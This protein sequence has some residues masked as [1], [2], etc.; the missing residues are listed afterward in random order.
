MR[1]WAR[2]RGRPPV[3]PPA[4]REL[5][6][7]L[8]VEKSVVENSRRCLLLDALNAEERLH[9]LLVTELAESTTNRQPIISGEN[10]F[11]LIMMLFQKRSM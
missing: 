10:S 11:D 8:S 5:P 4:E 1:W 7:V 9:A 2:S 3:V 6:D